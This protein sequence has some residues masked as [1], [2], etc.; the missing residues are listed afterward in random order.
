MAIQGPRLFGLG[1]SKAHATPPILADYKH[2]ATYDDPTKPLQVKTP[3]PSISD[4]PSGFTFPR[5]PH[6][7]EHLTKQYLGGRVFISDFSSSF[8]NKT[9]IRNRMLRITTPPGSVPTRDPDTLQ[10]H[11]KDIEGM[12]QMRPGEVYAENIDGRCLRTVGAVHTVESMNVYPDQGKRY[13]EAVATVLPLI[14]GNSEKDEPPIWEYSGVK[15]DRSDPNAPADSPSGSFNLAATMMKGEG[16]GT[17]VPA[18]QSSTPEGNI[19]VR[20][21]LACI[22]EMNEA[23]MEVSLSKFELSMIKAI[24]QDNNAWGYGTGRTPLIFTGLQQ[25]IAAILLKLI[26]AIAAQGGWHGDPGDH[27]AFV[28]VFN[29]FFSLVHLPP[30]CDLGAF[31]L[32]RHGLYCRE[33]DVAVISLIFRG[34]DLHSGY[35]ASVNAQMAS[36]YENAWSQYKEKH[37]PSMGEAKARDAFER[38]SPIA[39]V[40]NVSYVSANTISR[41]AGM[42]ISRPIFMGNQ[43]SGEAHRAR[44]RNF[45]EHGSVI[46]GSKTQVGQQAGQE[47]VYQFQNQCQVSGINLSLP[48]NDILKS[49]TIVDE[50]GSTRRLLPSAAQVQTDQQW[51][52]TMKVRGE[53]AWFLQI[54]NSAKVLVLKSEWCSIR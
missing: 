33:V 50:S 22:S 51:R 8:M 44:S 9:H 20:Q 11:V 38:L 39:R 48:V 21:F 18:A 42:S 27:P 52:E 10:L 3:N 40:G 46:I 13:R 15:N 45:V 5:S 53:I 24:C 25:N 7:H 31:E 47:Y 36:F 35:Q 19:R 16:Q 49:M 34:N 32:G 54:A 14:W 30:G 4:P 43:G 23:V 17:Y 37:A 6:W 28:T 29:L 12:V 1:G 41:L 2:A 26:R